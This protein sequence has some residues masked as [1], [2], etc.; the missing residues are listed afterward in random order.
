MKKKIILTTIV[1]LFLAAAINA[2]TAKSNF[3]GDWELDTV[4]STLPET[5]KVD[6]MKLKDSQTDKELTVESVTKRAKAEVRG[7]TKGSGGGGAQTVSYN[8]EGKDTTVDIGSGVMAGKET[9]KAVATAD[10]KLN[11]TV[12][13]KFDNEMV[14]VTVKT[15][16]I[17]E[18]LDEGTTLKVT[19][20]METP[21]GAVN[22]EMFFTGKALKSTLQGDTN[23]VRTSNESPA[24]NGTGNVPRKISGG[25]LNGKAI[26][27]PLPP[28]PAAA[29]AVRATGTVNVQVTINEQGDVISASA[30]SGHPLLRQAAEQAARE[31]RFAPTM[32]QGV[33]VSVT[34]VLVYNFVP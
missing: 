18:L 25:V 23:L 4:K 33:P 6:S 32:L 13:R 31:A 9:R 29:K 5:M 22:A 14:G 2:Q 15:N 30:V 21:R 10:G 20:Y 26:S 24:G 11:L 34:G 27:L 1:S 8:L 3:T 12:T 7:G 28:Y 17:W 19:R 16:E